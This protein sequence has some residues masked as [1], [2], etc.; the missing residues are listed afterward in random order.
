MAWKNSGQID[1]DGDERVLKAY[2]ESHLDELK[3]EVDRR[4]AK[5]AFEAKAQSPFPLTSDDWLHYLEE[6]E[7]HFRGL[8]KSAEQ[9]RKA[10]SHRILPIADLGNLPRVYPVPC[11]EHGHAPEWCHL[12]RG[13]YCFKLPDS[14]LVVFFVAA[15]SYSVYACPL[16]STATR[17]EYEFR[18]R[19][20]FHKVFRPISLV[21]EE[22]G[23]PD[24]TDTPVYAL[25]WEIKEFGSDNE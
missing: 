25:V 5:A 23:V 15:I 6:H 8:L 22:A 11:R 3:D 7:D 2:I 9:D 1:A 14:S 12:R 19:P 4:R 20:L 17:V 10:V 24:S 13:F 16:N 21:L 18:Y